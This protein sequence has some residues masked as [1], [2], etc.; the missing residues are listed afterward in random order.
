MVQAF[1]F[2]L[3]ADA[4]A[5]TSWTDSAGSRREIY[6]SYRKY[7]NMA[8]LIGYPETYLLFEM[9]LGHIGGLSPEAISN[10]IEETDDLS[11]T[12]ARHFVQV[13]T[14]LGT[15]GMT[16]EPTAKSKRVAS[17]VAAFLCEHKEDGQLIEAASEQV[18][19]LSGSLLC[20]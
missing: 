3:L 1:G 9:L 12:D 18:A 11:E 13:M 4:D 20:R 17:R 8:E 5:P 10:L 14:S 16:I 15:G 19:P 7:V 2:T 6:T